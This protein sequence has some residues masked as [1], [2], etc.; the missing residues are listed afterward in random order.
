MIN[1]KIINELRKKKSKSTI[2]NQ[3]DKIRKESG[4]TLTRDNAAYALAGSLGIDIGKYLSKEELEGLRNTHTKIREIKIKSKSTSKTVDLKIQG[5]PKNIPFLEKKTI[6]NCKKMSETYQ[7]FYLLENSIRSF[8]L[9]ILQSEYQSEDWWNTRVRQKIKD[10]V[11]IRTK[12]E[13][14]NRWHAQRGGHYIHYTD[15]RNLK[16]I[17]VDNWGIFKRFFP[18]QSWIISRLKEL[19]LSRNIIAHNNPLPQDEVSRIK[20]YLKDWIKQV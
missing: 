14:E 2:Y 20:L 19:E 3:I 12:K 8:I 11:V 10:A 9:S 16:E 4:Y 7:L 6:Q 1:K 17:I 18:D 13:K 5:I 15:F